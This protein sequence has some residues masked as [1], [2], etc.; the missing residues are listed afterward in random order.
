M[1]VMLIL[2]LVLPLRLLSLLLR[3]FRQQLQ[4]GTCMFV[5]FSC[6]LAVI[7]LFCFFTCLYVLVFFVP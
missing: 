1:S 6:F 3:S 5:L 7:Q 4:V 2:M